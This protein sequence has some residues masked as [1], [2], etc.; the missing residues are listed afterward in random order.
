[1]FGRLLLLIAVLI[2]AGCAGGAAKRTAAP[3]PD[4]ELNVADV[5]VFVEPLPGLFQVAN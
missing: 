5:D 2:Q 3:P 4:A 1:M